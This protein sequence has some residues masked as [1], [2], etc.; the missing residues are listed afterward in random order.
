MLV[1]I[2]IK[3]MVLTDRISMMNTLKMGLAVRRGYVKTLV[4][5]TGVS[6]ISVLC[7]QRNN[8]TLKDIQFIID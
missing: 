8:V 3:Y 6:H 1:V 4:I 7:P 5:K 2:L